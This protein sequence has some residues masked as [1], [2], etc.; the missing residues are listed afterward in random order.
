[1][2]G[3][4]VIMSAV[5]ISAHG[6]KNREMEAGF[7]LYLI[8]NTKAKA[9]LIQVCFRDNEQNVALCNSIGGAD[10]I[11][12]AIFNSIYDHEVTP[13][14]NPIIPNTYSH[15]FKKLLHKY[16]VTHDLPLPDLCT[17]VGCGHLFA[18]N[19]LLSSNSPPKLM[20]EIMGASV[21]AV[22]TNCAHV[23]LGIPQTVVDNYAEKI[24]NQE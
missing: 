8:K 12:Q 14:R 6:F 20:A 13:V 11:S 4:S 24:S 22:L 9:M 18:T 21:K 16:N 10:T 2:C 3:T 15:T 23:T 1:M 7:I 19:N 17:D 5:I